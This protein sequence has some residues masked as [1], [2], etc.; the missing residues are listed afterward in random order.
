MAAQE[1]IAV[2]VGN[3][4][5]KVGRFIPPPDDEPDRGPVGQQFLATPLSESVPWETVRSWSTKPVPL[6]IA[7]SNPAVMDEVSRRWQQATGELA[8]V[9]RDRQKLPLKTSVE[10]PERVGLDRLLN[11]IAANAWRPHGRPA[12][13]IDTGTATTVD[14]VTAQG[15]FAGGA[16]LPGLALS[17]KALH[18][19]TALL[20]Q[21][22]LTD[23]GPDLPSPL[24]RN[25]RD[26]LRSGLFWGQVGAIRQLVADLSHSDPVQPVPP[27]VVLT[28]GGA[29]WLS[30]ALQVDRVAS[31]LAMVGL[32]LTCWER[33]EEGVCSR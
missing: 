9:L 29:P 21:L 2:D 30:R 4:R 15:V 26:A 11:A 12:V 14:L 5:I 25:T 24:G 20:P 16:I 6:V 10:S 27:W 18:Q 7:G 22:S 33:G 17:A 1:L 3:T 13:V 31:S 8:W 19:Y 32:V 28:G 23:L